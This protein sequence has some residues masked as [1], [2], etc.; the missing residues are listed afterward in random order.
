MVAGRCL[1]LLPKPRRGRRAL[2]SLHTGRSALQEMR[3]L[4]KAADKDRQMAENH[5]HDGDEAMAR[6]PCPLTTCFSVYADFY[7]YHSGIYHHVSGA[8]EGGHC[9]CCIGY[10]DARRY[11]IC[12]NS[13]NTT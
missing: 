5:E 2:F 12:K 11:W 8:L 9:V 7:S 1:G 6:G 4:E 10:D 3:G 13:W